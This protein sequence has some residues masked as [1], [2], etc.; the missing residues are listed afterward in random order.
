[1]THKFIG[2][3]EIIVKAKPWQFYERYYKKLCTLNITVIVYRKFLYTASL[4]W[5]NRWTSVSH[6]DLYVHWL[7]FF[8]NKKK[9]N[10]NYH[11]F[12]W[13]ADKRCKEKFYNYFFFN[14][15]GKLMFDY[16]KKKKL[17]I[18]DF[19]NKRRKRLIH[20]NSCG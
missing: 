5:I 13:F 4:K 10:L 6:F 19:K 3:F 20:W 16:T 18:F 9:Q 11:P 2:S 14:L 1:M 12:L 15:K 7:F 8:R 17:K